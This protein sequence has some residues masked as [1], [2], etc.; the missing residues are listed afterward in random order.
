MENLDSEIIAILYG[1]ELKTMPGYFKLS[2][3][4]E[5]YAPEGRVRFYEYI[6]SVKNLQSTW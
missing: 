1:L 2:N 4:Q 3:G 6:S 5:A